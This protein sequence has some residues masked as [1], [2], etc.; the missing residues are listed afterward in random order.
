[1][2]SRQKR[3][4]MQLVLVALKLGGTWKKALEAKNTNF[5]LSTKFVP[6]QTAF[7]IDSIY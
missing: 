6:I 7:R 4:I 1:M 5:F 2:I 3:V